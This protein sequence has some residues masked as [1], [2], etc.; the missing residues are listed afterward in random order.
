MSNHTGRL[1]IICRT[2]RSL[3]SSMNLRTSI[4]PLQSSTSIPKK[5][6]LSALNDYFSNSEKIVITNDSLLR[7]FEV[8]ITEEKNDKDLSLGNIAYNLPSHTNDGYC[9]IERN[10]LEAAAT[11]EFDSYDA[12]LKAYGTMTDRNKKNHIFIVGKRYYINFNDEENNTDSLREVNLYA[13][14]VRTTDSSD[15]ISLK[16]VPVKI[17]QY[18]MGIYRLLPNHRGYEKT[19]TMMMNVPIVGYYSTGYSEE[20]F[21]IQ[22]DH[23][24]QR[25]EEAGEERLYGGSLQYRHLQPPKRDLQRTDK[26]LRLRLSLHRLPAKAGSPDHRLPPVLPQS[27]R[28]LPGQYWA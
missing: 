3:I 12:L 28:C 4:V 6:V 15:D 23:R 26:S 13:D 10:I 17:A 14:L 1:P 16:I 21:N 7:E 25:T 24:G 27:E 18:D 8:E 19:G 22:R 11:Q 20:S 5:C 2:G 9:R